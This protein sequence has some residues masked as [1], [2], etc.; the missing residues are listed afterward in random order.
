MQSN[1]HPPSTRAPATGPRAAARRHLEPVRRGLRSRR[2][3]TIY[4][5]LGIP[6]ALF[7]SVGVSYRLGIGA[8][9]VV[10]VIVA[11]WLFETFATVCRR[12]AF[13]G[14]TNC[15]LPGMIVP[16]LFRRRPAHEISRRRIAVH[17]ALDLAMVGFVNAIYL[18]AFP[19]LWPVIAACSVVGYLF[20]LRPKRFHGLSHRPPPERPFA[21]TN[22]VFTVSFVSLHSSDTVS[23]S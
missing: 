4:F 19:S 13:Y 5:G 3:F 18:L 22:V 9:F 21:D 17:R 8:G 1:D 15:L 7:G 14:T 11:A 16:F 6:P 20:V 12:C 23:G 10:T 2:F